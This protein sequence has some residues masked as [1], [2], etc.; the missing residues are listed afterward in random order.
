MDKLLLLEKEISKLKKE[1]MKDGECN[2]SEE[3][4]EVISSKEKLVLLEEK[5]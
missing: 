3:N 4:E 1:I 5:K 2:L